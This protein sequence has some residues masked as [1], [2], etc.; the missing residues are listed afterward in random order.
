MQMNITQNPKSFCMTLAVMVG[1]LALYWVGLNELD[2]NLVQAK[3]HLRQDPIVNTK[4]GEV[5][6]TFVYRIRHFDQRNEL[7]GCLAE[8][9]FY[10]SGS[11]AAGMSYRVVVCRS[12]SGLAF[13]IAG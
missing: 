11:K 5:S 6:S 2:T 1:T 12:E 9:F 13:K 3:A 8:Y 7:N 10:V 4:V